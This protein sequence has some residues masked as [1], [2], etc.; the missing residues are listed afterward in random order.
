M[1]VITGPTLLDSLI[2]RKLYIG[3]SYEIF[4]GID[5]PNTQVIF[6]VR[7]DVV[8]SVLSRIIADHFNIIEPNPIP[9]KQ[10]AK[11]FVAEIKKVKQV[12]LQQIVWYNAF[13]YLLKPNSN[14]VE[15]ELLQNFLPFDNENSLDKELIIENYNEAVQ[16]IRSQFDKEFLDNHAEFLDYKARLGCQKVYHALQY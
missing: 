14:V 8:G 9:L 13:R 7:Q 1:P 4:T 15:Y 16:Y 10:R 6:S 5:F 12:T 2:D 11:P 3:V